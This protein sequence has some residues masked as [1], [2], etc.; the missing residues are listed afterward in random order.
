MGMT[1][2]KHQT[3][4]WDVDR[5]N[6]SCWSNLSVLCSRNLNGLEGGIGFL[7]MDESMDDSPELGP[8]NPAQRIDDAPYDCMSYLSGRARRRGWTWINF[9]SLVSLVAIARTQKFWL[10]FQDFCIM[11]KCFNFAPRLPQC[12]RPEQTAELLS[13]EIGWHAN[14]MGSRKYCGTHHGDNW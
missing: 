10:Q 2:K 7:A 13:I 8:S 5:F 3:W 4:V 14:R 6:V 11:I 12:R 9:A 1:I